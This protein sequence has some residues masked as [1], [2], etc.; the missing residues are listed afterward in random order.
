MTRL[1]VTNMIGLIG[2]PTS[3]PNTLNPA[4]LNK[5]YENAVVCNNS[6]WDNGISFN[7]Y[8]VAFYWNSLVKP[9]SRYEWY[10][11][12]DSSVKTVSSTRRRGM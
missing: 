11:G 7:N 12:E 6:Y 5:Y 2:Y 1:S 9:T 4:E 10:A 3:D 8:S